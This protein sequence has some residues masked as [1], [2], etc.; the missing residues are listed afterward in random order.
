MHSS[1]MGSLS[2]A[3]RYALELRKSAEAFWPW[4][5]SHH[6]ED[7]HNWALLWVG[8]FFGG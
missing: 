6:S 3:R 5:V 8:V 7:F 4:L 2:D 1:H